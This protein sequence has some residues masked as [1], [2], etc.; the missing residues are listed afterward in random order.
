DEE[1]AE[2]CHDRTP[3]KLESGGVEDH[4]APRALNVTAHPAQLRHVDPCPTDDRDDGNDGQQ[5]PADEAPE[6]AR[7][8]QPE[9]LSVRTEVSNEP[10]D[11]EPV[12]DQLHDVDRKVESLG[13]GP[14][15]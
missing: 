12:Q 8:A 15:R 14:C 3:E 7:E 10:L 13:L 1:A 4:L 11:Q 2:G 5:A 6:R 9:W